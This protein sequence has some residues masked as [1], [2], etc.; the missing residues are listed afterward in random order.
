MVREILRSEDLPIVQD[1]M[2]GGELRA[3]SCSMGDVM[4]VQD[5]ETGPVYSVAFV[6]ACCAMTTITK[7]SKSTR[8]FFSG[9]SKW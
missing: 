8:L 3:L 1:K 6:Q 7:T 2:F 5:L 4:L 9:I